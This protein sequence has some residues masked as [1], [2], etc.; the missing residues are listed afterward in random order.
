MFWILLLE[1]ISMP[2]CCSVWRHRPLYV[3]PPQVN[4]AIYL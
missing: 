3:N 4:E 1:D 2:G